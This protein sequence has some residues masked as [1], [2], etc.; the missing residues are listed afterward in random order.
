[1]FLGRVSHV[2][3]PSVLRVFLCKI[4]H[5][6]VPVCLCQDRC[7]GDRCVLSV[8]FD[9]A[10]VLISVERLESV[11]VDKQELRL[12]DKSSYR[13]LHAGYGSIEYV[14]RIDFF[15][16]DF[17][18]RPCDSFLFDNGT[19]DFT[20]FLGHLLGVIQKWVVEIFRKNDGGS[21]NGAGQ[22]S[23]A[24]FVTSRFNKIGVEI[25]QEM[26]FFAHSAKIHNLFVLA[27]GFFEHCDDFVL[28]S[29]CFFQ[30][31][32]EF[33]KIGNPSF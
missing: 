6:F 8:T 20:R 10:L 4:P 11:S 15:S 14:D 27:K 23:S 31:L 25:I 7:G 29:D 28:G 33:F 19:Q 9:H 24:S 1:M 17:L 21:K 13:P 5:V 16:G 30:T 12:D 32:H 3:V 18:D 26:C 2:S 22:R